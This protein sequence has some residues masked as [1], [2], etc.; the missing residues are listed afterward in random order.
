MDY[1][2][3]SYQ[4]PKLVEG[5]D[6]YMHP[7]GFRIMTEKFLKNRG[8]CCGSGCKHCPYSPKHTKGNTVLRDDL[9]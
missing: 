9:K 1:I 3:D 2:D 5:E 7:K 8:Y 6:Y 4:P